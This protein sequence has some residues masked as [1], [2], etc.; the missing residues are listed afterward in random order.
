LEAGKIFFLCALEWLPTMPLY[1][2]CMVM[3]FPTQCVGFS[4][5]KSK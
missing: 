2:S 5:S 1:Q 4:E 3:S